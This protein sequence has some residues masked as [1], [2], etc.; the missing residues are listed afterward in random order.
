MI[1]TVIETERLVL[2]RPEDRDREALLAMNA[3]PRVA[4]WLAGPMTAE[5]NDA[6]IAR[7]QA[8]CDEKGYGFWA[9]ER[10]S[11]GKV[12]GLAGLLTMGEDLPP[13]PALEIGWRFAVEAWGQG[14]A[15]EGARA[16][17]AWAFAE[18]D[19]PEVVAITARTNLR[20]QA[21]MRRI[22]MVP[23]P[24]RDFDHPRVPDESPLKAHVTFVAARPA[25]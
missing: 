19:P 6:L 14:Y 4:E 5:Q 17:L 8:H 3:D 21:V 11:D 22:G 1:E 23:V 13:G 12:L 25:Q 24:A 2:R 10:K 15:T 16:A 9:A 20:S 7:I 18:L